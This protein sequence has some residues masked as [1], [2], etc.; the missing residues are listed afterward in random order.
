MALIIFIATIYLAAGFCFA[1]AL[2]HFIKL[3]FGYSSSDDSM[4]CNSLLQYPRKTSTIN[5]NGQ[6]IPIEHIHIDVDPGD[7]FKTL[8]LV[9]E[10]GNVDT[11]DLR[12]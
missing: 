6:N 5:F 10:D 7:E 3:V 1:Y 4:E 2:Y 8:V 12:N 9:D 11:F